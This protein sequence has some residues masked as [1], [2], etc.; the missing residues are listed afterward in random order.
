AL[1]PS[2]G[3]IVDDSGVSDASLDTI[4]KIHARGPGKL[5]KATDLPPQD[6]D[7]KDLSGLADAGATGGWR[8]QATP[9]IKPSL[10]GTPHSASMRSASALPT[11]DSQGTDATLQAIKQVH[12][13]GPTGMWGR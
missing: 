6:S 13:M 8:D 12:A 2:A 1:K 11:Q 4:R 3:F 10:F 5:S 9:G 7:I